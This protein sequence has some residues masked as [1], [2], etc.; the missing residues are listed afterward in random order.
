MRDDAK[1]VRS[2]FIIAACWPLVLMGNA[3]AV[4]RLFPKLYKALKLLTLDQLVSQRSRMNWGECSP[5]LAAALAVSPRLL[6]AADHP[7]HWA[8]VLSSAIASQVAR[9]QMGWMTRLSL[10]DRPLQP[11]DGRENH[12]TRSRWSLRLMMPEAYYQ[13]VTLVALGTPTTIT[14]SMYYPTRYTFHPYAN[15]P[16]ATTITATRQTK[17]PLP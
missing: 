14:I 16:L 1:E 3:V 11:A 2:C 13:H 10:L 12:A 5:V 4:R 15:I 9:I 8:L 6:V 17:M 7:H